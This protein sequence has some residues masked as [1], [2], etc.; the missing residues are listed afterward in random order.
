MNIK[1]AKEEVKNT[2]KAYL[3]KDDH[4]QYVIPQIRQRPM[5]LI[6]PPGIGKTQIMEQI[7]RECGIGLVAYTITHHT[8]QSAVGLPFI[9]EREYDGTTY[10]VTEYTMSEIIASV[11]EKMEKSGLKEG[12]LFIDEIN[13]VSETLA[14]TMLQFLQCKTF[15]N[16]AVPDG[17]IIVAAGN[18]PEYNKSVRDFDMVTL[19][20]V[21]YISIE[22]DYDV[23]KEYARKVHEE[24]PVACAALGRLMT[25]GAMMGA[26]MKGDKDLLTLQIRADGPLRGMTVTADAK[27]N[28]KG[29]AGNPQVMLPPN[30]LGKLD[31]G[32]A[33]GHGILNVI[34]DMGMK[35]PYVGQVGLQTGEIAEDLTYYFATSEQVASSVGLGVLMN[36]DNTVRQAGGF[37]IQLMP[38]TDEK[39]I[40]ALEK[41]LSSVKSVTSM[42]DAG[43]TPEDILQELLGEF[44][45]EITEKTETRFACN[46]SKERME[47]ALISIGR[48]DLEEMIKDG[49]PIEMNCHF[50][51][52]HYQF[53]V[54]EL[55]KILAQAK[56]R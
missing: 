22:A 23:W 26:M 3:L 27:G 9:K 51:N 12:I 34:K 2:V 5:L 20:R 24:S 17:W 35:E 43:M 41:K 19:D 55:K 4:G 47:K 45:V 6:G 25:A 8:R 1:T 28:V 56:K 46:C 49:E 29:F 7:A 53:S 36:H 48:K 44:G 16:Q 54:E 52:S 30:A 21:R 32:G 38:F 37:I 31:V 50:C 40:D 10:S 18:P 39:V 42:L 15:G 13:C 33:V 14:P 11:Y